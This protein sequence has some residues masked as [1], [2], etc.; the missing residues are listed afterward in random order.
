MVEKG[1]RFGLRNGADDP[2]SIFDKEL[3]FLSDKEV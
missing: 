1:L 3:F 2:A